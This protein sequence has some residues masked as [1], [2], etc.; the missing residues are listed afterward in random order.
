[1]FGTCRALL[2]AVGGLLVGGLASSAPVAAQ[3]PTTT[4]TG[5]LSKGLGK[6]IFDLK[7]SDGRTYSLTSTNV[8]LSQHVGHRVTVTGTSAG[9]ETGALRDTSKKIDTSMKK[10][11][12][13]PFGGGG[14]TV[15]S[16]KM[17]STQCK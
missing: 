11:A 5:C 1:M 12:G 7:S 8:K 16:L 17:V 3:Q 14:L 9:I 10:A 13:A 6:D 4:V 15:T 2:A